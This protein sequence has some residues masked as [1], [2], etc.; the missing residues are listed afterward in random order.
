MKSFI[1]SALVTA[2]A[3][4]PN[5]VAQRDT[6]ATSDVTGALK[7]TSQSGS[8]QVFEPPVPAS[9]LNQTVASTGNVKLVKSKLRN[10]A[11][12]S[13]WGVNV[14]ARSQNFLLA[15]DT[16]GGDTWF[17][18]KDFQCVAGLY[19]P[20][21]VDQSACAPGSSFSN[22]FGSGKDIPN[23]GSHHSMIEFLLICISKH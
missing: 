14:K 15:I 20:I 13:F 23:V 16:A 4:V 22:G 3:A 2:A 8:L 5:N 11:F 17:Y 21:E 19:E 1:L 9:A 18:D 10:I 12:G 7:V 6:F